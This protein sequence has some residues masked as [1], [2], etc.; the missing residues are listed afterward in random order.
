MKDEKYRKICNVRKLPNAISNNP[1][2]KNRQK[3]YK[4]QMITYKIVP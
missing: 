1:K 4:I 3:E 2:K